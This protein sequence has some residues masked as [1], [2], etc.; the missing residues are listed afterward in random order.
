M[1]IGIDA[2]HISQTHKGN[3]RLERSIVTALARLH[4]VHEFVVF[5]GAPVHQLRLPDVPHIMYVTA[6]STNLIAWEQIIL[7]CL[8]RR[9]AT[10]CL[11]TFSDRI[12][13]W[14]PKRVVMYVAEIPDY[15]I[16]MNRIS[17]AG[18]YQHFSDLLTRLIFPISLR[19][20]M[21]VCA[22]SHATMKD[23]IAQYGVPSN[24]LT[25]VFEAASEQ[26]QPAT[27]DTNNEV[28]RSRYDSAA[29]YVLH[30][31]TGDPR[32]NTFVALQAFAEADIPS[33]IRL[34]L[35][36]NL[37]RDIAPLI[38]MAKELNVG[39]RVRPLGCVPDTELLEL[40]QTADVFID[41][42]LYEGFGLQVLEA[43]ACGVPVVCSNVTSL[44]EIVGDA[45]ITCDPDDVAAFSAGL[46]AVLNNPEQA[47][48]MRAAGLRQAARFSWQRTARELIRI[49][50]RAAV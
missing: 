45:A 15:R 49:C 25:V 41:S 5:L 29:G 36:G 19:R 14:S 6:P 21:H 2:V 26:F 39:D 50:E 13:L 43:M 7:P 22:P 38:A 9:Y 23:L 47:T 40:Y 44:P 1:R 34:V 12:A 8:A 32:E 48:T 35:P 42:T 11:I 30:F 46:E 31:S 27:T 24:K 10:E 4:A 16:H 20:S 18:K 3:A 28:V 37:D 17:N 33:S